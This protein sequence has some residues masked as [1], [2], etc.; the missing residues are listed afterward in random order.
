MA[1]DETIDVTVY[2]ASR[3][4]MTGETDRQFGQSVRWD[5]PLLE[6]YKHIFLSN[7]SLR[8]SIY[9]FWGLLNLSVIRRLWEAPKSVLIVYGWAY[10][11][12]WLVILFGN[13]LGH[14]ICLRGESPLKHE[15]LKA[16]WKQTVRRG[17]LRFGLFPL[18]D[19]FLY[20]GKQNKAFYQSFG[21]SENRLIFTPYAI[22]NSRFR[23]YAEKSVT[24]KGQN[25]QRLTLPVDK[26]IIL[27]SG[28]YIPKKRPMDLIRAF[29]QLNRPDTALVMMGEGE[30]RSAMEEY[31]QENKLT[32]VY[33]TGFVNQSKVLEYYATADVYV[34]CS[35]VG[36]TW[37]LST[38]EAMLFGLPVVLSDLVGCAED[39]LIEGETGFGFRTGDIDGLVV[40]LNRLLDLDKT[41]F[42]TLRRRSAE[43]VA[44]YN[45]NVTI[46]S[47]KQTFRPLFE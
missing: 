26:R 28:K 22:D 23:A 5:I 46:S 39:L 12:N 17:L 32:Q 19:Y 33:L 8:P 9:S 16:G 1:R 30:L 20:I 35:G 14:T 18:V 42:E 13:L 43:Q 29:H 38:N 11:V 45:Y 15:R 36:E 41:T 21:V 44:D 40:A 10:A 3:H 24:N 6:G 25:R 37:G 7:H 34:M 27:Y 2:Y 31:I 4:G 47:L